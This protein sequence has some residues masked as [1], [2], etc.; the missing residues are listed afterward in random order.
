MKTETVET[1]NNQRDT[2]EETKYEYDHYLID[3]IE[4]SPTYSV[5]DTF[6]F[7]YVEEILDV[8][9]DW[10]RGFLESVSQQTYPLT[11]KQAARVN[12]ALED[13][14]EGMRSANR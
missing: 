9:D 11:Q 14:L 12:E 2:H 13:A 5:G 7:P 1:N 8:V 6:N 4:G 10:Q 3:A